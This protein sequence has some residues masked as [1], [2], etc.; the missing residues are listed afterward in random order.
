MGIGN[1][2]VAIDNFFVSDGPMHGK[3]LNAA[4]TTDWRSPVYEEVSELVSEA[5]SEAPGEVP[6]EGTTQHIIN[7]VRLPKVCQKRL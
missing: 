1:Y 4:S 3:V 6:G 7:K 2:A 5:P